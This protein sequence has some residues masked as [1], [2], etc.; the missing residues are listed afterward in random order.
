MPTLWTTPSLTKPKKATDLTAVPDYFGTTPSGTAAGTVA[1]LPKTPGADE[2]IFKQFEDVGV[3][4]DTSNEAL[5][6]FI[7]QLGATQGGLT[8]ATGQEVGNLD[9]VFQP[10]GYQQV[11]QTIRQ[12]RANALSKVNQKILDGIRRTLGL[13]RTGSGGLVGGGLGGYLAQIA[14]SEAGKLQANEAYD[15]A[16]N[17]RADALALLQARLGAQ[18]Q[19]Q[20]LTD[21]LLNRLL[22]PVDVTSKSN[23]NLSDALTRALQQIQLNSFMGVGAQVSNPMG[24]GA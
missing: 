5:S 1:R 11:L 24:M 8:S 23:A 7:K 12:N 20:T 17:E 2:A 15:A 3:L 6:S 14:A 22:V 18:G 4:R 16:A 21:T 13:G 19:R 9:A 10:T